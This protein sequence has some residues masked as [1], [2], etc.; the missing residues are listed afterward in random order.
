MDKVVDID[1]LRSARGGKKRAGQSN[2]ISYLSG[3][4]ITRD[5]SIKAKCYECNGMGEQLD[6]D[7]EACALFPYSPYAVARK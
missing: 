4:R 3:K 1:M 2:L 7:I 6:C 5:Q